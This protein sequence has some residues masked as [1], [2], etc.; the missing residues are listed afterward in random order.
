MIFITFVLIFLKNY[1]FARLNHF[2]HQ[3]FSQFGFRGGYVRFKPLMSRIDLVSKNLLANCFRNF[4]KKRVKENY[5]KN[6][7]ETV[8]VTKIAKVTGIFFAK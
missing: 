6:R 4:S 5:Q 7:E 3:K 2:I 1:L 8:N